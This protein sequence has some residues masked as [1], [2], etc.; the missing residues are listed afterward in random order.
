MDQK[1]FGSWQCWEEGKEGLGNWGLGFF[2]FFFFFFSS[3]R[4]KRR[5]K[6]F[7]L[8]FFFFSLNDVVLTLSD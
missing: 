2:S 7:V 4:S 5:R 1:G 8:I 3:R 6:I